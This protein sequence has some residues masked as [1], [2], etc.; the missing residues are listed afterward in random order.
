MKRLL[1]L[2][3]CIAS[4]AMQSQAQTFYQLYI[5][6]DIET[7]DYG[8]TA[9][10]LQGYNHS[11][12]S[13]TYA[14]DQLALEREDGSILSVTIPSGGG[15]DF[16][17]IAGNAGNPM[18]GDLYFTA[19]RPSVDNDNIAIGTNAG[20]A[21]VGNVAVGNNS[22]ASITSNNNNNIALGVSA[23]QLTNGSSNVSMGL[24]ALSQAT[25]GN[26]NLA[27]GSNSLQISSGDYNIAIGSNAGSVNSG[28][29]TNNGVFI[30]KYSGQGV[31]GDDW[32]YI[33]NSSSLSNTSVLYGKSTDD[34]NNNYI[35]VNGDMYVKQWQFKE[36]AAG[37]NIY[38][39]GTFKMRI[40]TDGDLYL[41]GTTVHYNA[42]E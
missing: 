29:P 28:L 40:G 27:L 6:K 41:S 8:N 26:N 15:G 34:V 30:G 7:V 20:K 17:P 21:G 24:L 36:V 33:G 2:M 37:L 18:T 42:T 9:N 25:S 13:L 35:V 19:L 4:F 39:N 12:K 14:G 11:V 1:L 32:V 10:W 31:T 23:M 22:L 38:F 5:Y 16:V 3:I